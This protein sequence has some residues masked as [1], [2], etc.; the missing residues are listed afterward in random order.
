MS[1]MDQPLGVLIGD[2]KYKNGIA[3]ATIK[4]TADAKPVSVNQVIMVNISYSYKYRDKKTKVISKRKANVV[5]LLP[6][7]RLIVAVPEK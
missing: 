1:L 3:T 6:A 7:R 2:V 4:V 5:A